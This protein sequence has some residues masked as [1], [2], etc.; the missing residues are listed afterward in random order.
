M[1][2]FFEGVKDAAQSVWCATSG[3]A[4]ALWDAAVGAANGFD[5]TPDQFGN[6][7]SRLT[8]N[9][10][11][12]PQEDE[13]PPTCWPKDYRIDYTVNYKDLDEDPVVNLTLTSFVT[14]RGPIKGYEWEF[15]GQSDR[16]PAGLYVNHGVPGDPN[17]TAR[18]FMFG[19]GS[20]N[21]GNFSFTVDG[22]TD[23]SPNTPCSLPPVIPPPTYNPGDWTGTTNINF[24]YIDGLDLTIPVAFFIGL[25]KIDINGELVVP[26]N[27][28][29]SPNI[30]IDPT[31]DFNIDVHIPIGGGEPRVLPPNKGPSTG[32]DPGNPP[33][34]RPDDFE[35]VPQPPS[36]PPS[37]PDPGNPT[38]PDTTEYCVIRAAVVT[39]TSVS[40]RAS[41]TIIGQDQNPDIYAPSLGYINFA[42]R[43]GNGSV[44]WGEDLPVKNL[45]QFFEVSWP[46]GA[47]DV[48][49]TPK[50]G[51]LWSITPIWECT[52]L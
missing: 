13:R 11:P 4:G 49:G 32:P 29:F 45:R 44:A 25:A 36:K 39:T 12:D 38:K 15:Q 19:A 28:D 40:D 2:T 37:V 22:V 33:V 51:I 10:P 26:V 43:F 9:K 14:V 52:N 48:K 47:V 20:P 35:P 1:G 41:P 17:G 3:L 16:G 8:C 23:L 5:F 6:F 21:D 31:F 24:T 34:P 50:P 18:T 7:A 27:L 42:Y 46:A 30:N